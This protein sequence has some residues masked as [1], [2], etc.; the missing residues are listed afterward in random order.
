[1]SLLLRPKLPHVPLP[2]PSDPSPKEGTVVPRESI[3]AA[4]SSWRTAERR[5]ADATTDNSDELTREVVRC[6]DVFQ[7][8]SAE[9]MI[10]WIAKLNDAESRR[11]HATPS[12][13]PFHLAARDTQE[14]AAEIW[15]AARSSDED[16]PETAANRRT[17]PRPSRPGTN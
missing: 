7:R 14:I 10:E 12:T 4:L 16:T 9:H 17:T 11:S 2:V 8:L 5:L 1:M 15:E 6:R 3:E 13:L